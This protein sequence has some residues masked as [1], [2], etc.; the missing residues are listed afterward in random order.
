MMRPGR[1]KYA[2]GNL[3]EGSTEEKARDADTYVSYCAPAELRGET[4]VHHVELSLFPGWVGGDQERLVEL[5][6]DRLAL[7]STRP[8]LQGDRRVRS[9]REWLSAVRARLLCCDEDRIPPVGGKAR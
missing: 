1:E 3:F 5:T 2:A 7:S 4:V 9:R 6:R 8:F